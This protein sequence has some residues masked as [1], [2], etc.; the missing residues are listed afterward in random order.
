V[1]SHP[2]LVREMLVDRQD[3][4]RKSPA[5]RAA[6]PVLGDGLLTSEGETHR[7]HR[8]LVQP[9]V[10]PA[11]LGGLGQAVARHV[12]RVS[13]AWRDGQVV[14]VGRSMRDLT[15]GVAAEALFGADLEREAAALSE[16]LD[17]L[18]EAYESPLLVLAGAAPWL[19]LPALRRWQSARRSVATLVR[20]R[21]LDREHAARD[22]VLAALARARDERGTLTPSEVEDEVVTLLL[23]GHETTASTLAWTLWLLASHPA[24]AGEVAAEARGERE[25]ALGHGALDRLAW[26]RGAV[27]EALR[28]YPPSWAM[29]RQALRDVRIGEHLLPRGSLAIASQWV[30][31][32]DPRW[33]RDPA[34][35][36]PA[37]WVDGEAD[38]L[39]AFAYFP[40]G[41]GRRRC[42]GEPM[43]WAE[44]VLAVATLV[45][46]WRF[47]EV[48]GAAVR[49]RALLTLRPAGG[50]PLRV[51]PR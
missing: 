17:V 23:A 14:D 11:R 37:R 1:L 18:L 34:A 12:D 36:D 20:E 50:V 22:D 4:F 26:T 6:R 32:R 42:V 24:A 30:V 2:D 15:L 3:A 43:A 25:D 16:A 29:G 10:A 47:E 35:F 40:F 48:A 27:A 8:R 33:W 46:R 41:G 49:P 5:L 45:R 31:H 19:P 51:A 38:D 39:P 44:T 28:L 7:R 9:A 13:S 21:V